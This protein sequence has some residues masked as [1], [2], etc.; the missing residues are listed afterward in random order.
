[1][2]DPQQIEK[3][4]REYLEKEPNLRRADRLTHLMVIFNKHFGLS[5]LDHMVNKKDLGDVI[6]GAKQIFVNLPINA[7]ISGTLVD[8]S[9][10]PQVAVIESFISYLNK[11][12]LL[13]KTVKFDYRDSDDFEVIE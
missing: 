13:K 8:K 12:S 7:S 3:D 4:L 11:N 10:L 6:S 5:Q 2:S 9:E 1:M